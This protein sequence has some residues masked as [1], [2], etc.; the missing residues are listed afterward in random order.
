MPDR[1]SDAQ[2]AEIEAAGY[3]I[4]PREPSP[5]LLMSMAIRSDHALGMPGYYDNPL[6]AERGITHK[7]RLEAALTA[8]RQAHEEVVC[9]GFYKPEREPAYCALLDP[10]AGPAEPTA[11]AGFSARTAK[12]SPAQLADVDLVPAEQPSMAAARDVL[13][14]RRR[15]IEAEGWTPEHDD[16]HGLG[17]LARAAASYA[18]TYAAEC[19]NSIVTEARLVTFARAIWPWGLG[20][21]KSAGGRRRLLVK[22]G[23]LILA[24]IERLDRAG[25]KAPQQ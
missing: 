19:D 11:I 18:A 23:A 22:A 2:R 15:Q 6:F 4:I 14:E 20:W 24:E 3:V 8:A 1:L 9:A 16:Q 7:M 25:S 21:F 10:T 13:A 17:E 5:G 12:D